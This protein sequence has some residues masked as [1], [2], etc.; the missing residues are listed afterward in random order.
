MKDSSD[1][2]IDR[3]DFLNKECGTKNAGRLCQSCLVLPFYNVGSHSR[4]G[5]TAAGR[6]RARIRPCDRDTHPVRRGFRSVGWP[7]ASAGG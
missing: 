2:T 5:L 4:S 1:W 7:G 3:R 6:P